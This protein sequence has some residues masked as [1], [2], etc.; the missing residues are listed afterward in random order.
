MRK[1]LRV[2]LLSG[3][4]LAGCSQLPDPDLSTIK[5]G[6]AVDSFRANCREAEKPTDYYLERQRR[7]QGQGPLNLSR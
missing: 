2:A 5:L 4:A 3:F 6:E 7:L 1:S